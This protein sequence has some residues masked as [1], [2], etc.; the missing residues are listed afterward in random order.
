[1]SQQ[2]EAN[3]WSLYWSEDRL[4]S[5]VAQS[6]DE[7][8]RVLNEL[9]RDFSQGLEHNSRLLDLATGNGAVVDAL[10]SANSTLR[11]DAIDKADI[12]PQKYLRDN[13]NF[14]DVDFH[15]GTDILNLPFD[16]STFDAITSQ[17]GIEYAGLG[18]AS[19]R[20]MRNLKIGGRFQFVIHHAQSGIILSSKKK[21]LELEQLTQESGILD[22]LMGVI[23]GKAEFTQLEVLG[24]KYLKQNLT[25]TEQ[26][27][28]QV[29]A[30]IERVISGFASHPKESYQLGVAMDLRVRSE[31]ARLQQLIEAGQTAESMKSW[32]EQ[33][34]ANGASAIYEPLYLD[35][36]KQD[37]LLGWLATGSR[38]S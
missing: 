28:G 34:S 4:Y 3:A 27:S 30:G 7:D 25:R 12:D 26:I 6:S 10:K 15:A 35:S 9:W 8:Q 17:F 19:A 2:H 36:S 24:Q 18:G 13:N 33:V 31:L 11:I 5:C 16:P 20:V 21:I 29:F 32:L 14:Q 37:Y 22:T 1:M 38:S 23:S